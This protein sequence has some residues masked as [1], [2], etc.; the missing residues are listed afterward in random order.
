MYHGRMNWK[1]CMRL[2]GRHRWLR[3]SIRT[4]LLTVTIGCV[5]LGWHV[6]VVWQRRA[7]LKFVSDHGGA[8]LFVADSNPFEAADRMPLEMS[9]VQLKLGDQLLRWIDVP[10]ELPERDVLRIK[11][12]FPD[13][14]VRVSEQPKSPFQSSHWSSDL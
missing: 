13:A 5:W 9:F 6:D 4:T 7:L 14:E 12:A 10:K 2:L 3:S 11:R 8:Y 1:S